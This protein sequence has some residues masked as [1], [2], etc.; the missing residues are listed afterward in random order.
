M[1]KVEIQTLRRFGSRETSLCDALLRLPSYSVVR[2]LG[3]A[4]VK[5]RWA[6]GLEFPAEAWW[7]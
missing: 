5:R 6:P 3:P 1:I 2:G 4:A 7:S